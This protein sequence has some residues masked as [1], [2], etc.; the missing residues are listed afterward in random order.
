MGDLNSVLR[1][2]VALRKSIIDDG[3]TSG[4]PFC[5]KD[6][7]TMLERAKSE[8]SSF[9]KVT[10]SVLGKALDRGLID[11]NLK[12]PA[13]FGAKRD[14]CL[15]RFCYAVFRTI[16]DDRGI[17]LANPNLSSVF[18][19]RQLLLFD[20]KLLTEPSLEQ[21]KLAVDGFEQ[22]QKTLR[23][24][25]V[26]VDHPV[27][28]RAQ[29]LL[30]SV[31]RNLDL[32][33]IDPGHGPGGVADGL[34]RFERWDFTEW[35][36]KAGRWYPHEKYGSS[37]FKALC[38][39]GAP[40]IRREMNTKCCLVPKDFKGPRLISAERTVNQYLQQGQMKKMMQYIESHRL[41]RKSIR[42][43]DQTFNQ[44]ICQKAYE[45]GLVTLDL[46]NASDTVSATLVWFLLAEVPKLRSQL[47]C[48]RSD[49]MIYENR[50]IKIAAFAPM[51]SA[52]CFPVET[53]VFWALSLASVRHV[54]SFWPYPI[55]R[56]RSP[57][58]EA[59]SSV[60]VFG[61]DIIIPSYAMDTL[62]GT[63]QSV[64]CEVNTSKTC[65]QTPFRESCGSEWY[66]GIDITII[67]NKE[68]QYDDRK[69][70]IDYPALLSLQRK[71]FLRG[72]YS[73]AAL[74]K[75]WAREIYPILTVTYRDIPNPGG[76]DHNFTSWGDIFR[77][78]YVFGGFTKRSSLVQSSR[79]ACAFPSVMGRLE[80]EAYPAD[81]FPAAIGQY[82]SLD[83]GVRVRYNRSYQRYECRLPGVFQRTREWPSPKSVVELL[84]PPLRQE[85]LS[86]DRS[87]EA[88]RLLC[89]VDGLLT[90]QRQVYARYL[91]RLAGDSVERIAIR[92]FEVKLAWTN[93]P[94]RVSFNTKPG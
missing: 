74:C 3:V 58:E 52:T 88:S 69:K 72:L 84:S 64:G 5:V 94:S 7:Q 92:T 46:S 40:N 36:Y 43:K 25:R 39:L 4:V 60:A 83:S 68:Y 29:K 10:F 42:L 49:F 71:L 24:V 53:L 82:T 37:S 2:F 90:P 20:S 28:L 15:P 79:S 38:E 93:L 9:F 23:K 61:D 81:T 30:G 86:A 70:L 54:T 89:P 73:A 91:A 47:F 21:R 26:P 16:F 27:V 14:T 76:V 22:R 11:G 62:V 66:N 59:S 51:G 35:P 65:F 17:L 80:L 55:S 32:S 12:I 33:V 45:D 63:L 18:F 87:E 6:S 1:R 48:T 78:K 67:R 57:L 19:L 77:G 8:G 75:D 41:L 50:K 85:G 56:V 13:S 31:L 34:D 44:R